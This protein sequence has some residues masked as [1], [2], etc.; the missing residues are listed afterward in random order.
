MRVKK[1]GG[2]TTVA[3]L[4]LNF[5]EKIMSEIK[6]CKVDGNYLNYLRQF[7]IKVSLDYTGTRKFVGILF[8]INNQKYYAP[9]SSPKPKHVNINKNSLDIYK[10]DGGN[11]GVINLNNMVPVPDE[12]VIIVDI[13]NELDIKYQTLLKNQIRVIKQDSERIKRKAR[14][15]YNHVKQN[16][17]PS[18]SQRCC[19]YTLLESKVLAYT[20]SLE[21]QIEYTK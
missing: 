6:I 14:I 2:A 9:M 7:D 11:L 5:R 4:V 13:E 18:L 17:N 10:I 20:I 8:E 21:N 12:A 3:P 19:Q 16:I 15:L 1:V